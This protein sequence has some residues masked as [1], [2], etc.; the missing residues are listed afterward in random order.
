[1]RS[2]FRLLQ[3]LFRCRRP[4]I[5]KLQFLTTQI[6][7]IARDDAPSPA[8]AGLFHEMVVIFV[9]QIGTPTKINARPTASG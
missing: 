5:G 3:K 7:Q 9:R 8:R 4:E 6:T 1:M 2:S